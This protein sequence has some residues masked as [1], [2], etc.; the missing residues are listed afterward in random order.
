M[1]DTPQNLELV[2]LQPHARSAPESKASAGEL[3]R[4]LFDRDGKACRQALDHGDKT[5]PMGLARGQEAQHGEPTT[6][7]YREAACDQG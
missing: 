4:D 1:P 6:S 5:G 3:R 7:G 2:L